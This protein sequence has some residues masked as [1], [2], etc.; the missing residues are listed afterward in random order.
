MNQINSAKGGS[1]AKNAAFNDKLDKM[2]QLIRTGGLMVDFC[3]DDP[4][5]MA[6]RV[7]AAHVEEAPKKKKPPTP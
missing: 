5:V 1:V 6:S 2:M 4:G 3:G 7:S